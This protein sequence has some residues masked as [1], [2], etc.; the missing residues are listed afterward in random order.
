IGDSKLISYPNLAAMARAEVAFIAPAS[1]QYVPVE[2][3]AAQE[4]SQAVEVDYVAARDAGKAPDRRGR[5]HVRDDVMNLPGP[6]TLA[7][8][9]TRR[10]GFGHAPARAQ[11]AAPARAK[12]LDRARD[13]LDRLA[14]A[15][16]GRHYP[17][18][19]AVAARVQAIG[20]DRRVAAY[21]RTDIGVDEH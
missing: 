13:D 12:K 4:L 19:A 7:P 2:V 5:W 21:L 9:L 20:R 16:G 10:R 18:P 14:R 15:L 17:D 8:V 11:A 6:P 1:K 3:L